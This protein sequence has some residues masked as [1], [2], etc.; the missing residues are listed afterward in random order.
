MRK[1]TGFMADDVSYRGGYLWKYAADLSR[2][3]GEAPARPTQIECHQ[4][5]TPYMGELFLEAWQVTGDPY[6]L[7]NTK[8]AANAL[9]WGQH[10]SGGWHYFIDFDM[11]GVRQ[12]YKDVA[13][14]FKWGMQEYRHFYGNCSFDDDATQAPTRFLLKLYM[15]TLDPAY[16]APLIK[17]LDFFLE[18]QYPNGGWPQRYPLRYEHVQ[19]GHPDYTSHYTFNDNVMISNIRVLYSAWE[20]LGNEAYLDAAIKGMDFYI[21]SQ[22][23]EDQAGWSD[24]HGMDLKPAWGRTHEPKAYMTAMTLKNIRELQSFYL[25]TGDRRYLAPIPKAIAWFENSALEVDDDGRHKVA[26]YY[27]VGT[28]KPFYMHNSEMVDEHGYGIHIFDD[29]PTDK[30]Y[31]Y[32]KNFWNPRKFVWVDIP[33]L[34]KGYEA[35]S[36]LT[37]REAQARYQAPRLRKRPAPDVDPAEVQSLISSMDKR[38]AWVETVLVFLEDHEMDGKP[39]YSTNWAN[40]EIQGIFTRSYVNN[41]RKFLNYLRNL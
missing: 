2:G 33:A 13:S 28:N 16:R 20:Q 26:A 40:S 4:F 5:G 29:D 37:P 23:S 41:M 30:L 9:I 10:P 39:A 8:K 3:W 7:E 35:I 32:E 27:E 25:M 34:K 22:G 18:S 6:Y 36:A 31:E 14:K 15:A 11:T 12:W 21:I 19:D 38:G 24:Q 17:A 1:A